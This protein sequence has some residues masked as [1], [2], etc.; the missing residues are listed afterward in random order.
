MPARRCVDCDLNVP[1]NIVGICPICDGRL[2]YYAGRN[3]DDNWEERYYGEGSTPEEQIPSG[4]PPRGWGPHP[5]NDSATL[6]YRDD[7]DSVWIHNDELVRLGYRNLEPFDV[8]KLNGKHYELTYLDRK[9]RF[10]EV[11]RLDFYQWA[12]EAILD[13]PEYEGPSSDDIVAMI[14]EDGKQI[15]FNPNQLEEGE[16]AA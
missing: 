5:E 13:L 9:T 12:T 16:D 3:P 6:I 2:L 8:V 10:W 14:G 7:M 11:E 1:L 4:K 15:Y